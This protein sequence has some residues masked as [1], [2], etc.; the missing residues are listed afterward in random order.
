MLLKKT[1]FIYPD[2]NAPAS[3]KACCTSRNGGVSDS[4]FSSLNLAT[5]VED[6]ASRVALNRQRLRQVCG[7]PAE[8]QWLTQTHSTHVINLDREMTRQG[9]AALTATPG[10]IA[11][12]LT[13]D[14]LPVLFCNKQGTEVA[15]AHAGWRGL[16]NGVLQQ[17][18]QQ[19]KSDSSDILAWLG[20]A[21][22]AL[23]FEV[24][25]EVKQAFIT[26]DTDN[27]HYFAETRTGHYLA[28]L[29]AIARLHLKKMGIMH[30][31]GGNYCTYRDHELFFSYRR[32]KNCGRQASLIYIENF[33]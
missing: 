25:E 18:V 26:A 29:Y 3:V 9:D 10:I 30:I 14:C 21:I 16:L 28:D 4:G 8:P 33:F 2:W 19:M 23:Q 31:S 24:G 1:D 6:D 15:A 27:S 12:V 22:G 32:E 17:T 11:V 13:A 7:L 5:H 20:P